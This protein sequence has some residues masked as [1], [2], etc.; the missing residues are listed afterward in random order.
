[1][2]QKEENHKRLGEGGQEHA[3]ILSFAS[4]LNYLD[5]FPI[6]YRDCSNAIRFSDRPPVLE[7]FI[8]EN[9]EL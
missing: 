4:A 8:P 1:M 9:G 3:M 7:F 2:Q 6:I 5:Y